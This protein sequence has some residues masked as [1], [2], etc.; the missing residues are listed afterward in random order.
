MLNSTYEI[1]AC[2]SALL[3]KSLQRILEIL[4]LTSYSRPDFFA[5]CKVV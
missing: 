3:Q 4:P 2:A 1:D 5:D